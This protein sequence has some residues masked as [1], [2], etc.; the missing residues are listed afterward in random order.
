MLAVSQ[1]LAKAKPAGS[2][3]S[4]PR[5]VGAML[6]LV[7]LILLGVVVIG[8]LKSWR[9]QAESGRPTANDQLAHFQALYQRGELSPE[10]FDRVRTRL[11]SQLRQELDLP[12]PPLTD[13]ADGPPATE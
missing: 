10:E 5:W 12:A 9:K 13:R 8:W 1:A 7:G 6:A 2:V 4:D 3:W 11:A